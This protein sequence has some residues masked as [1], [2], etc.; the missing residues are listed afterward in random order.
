MVLRSSDAAATAFQP[1]DL[2]QLIVVDVGCRRYF[3]SAPFG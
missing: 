1:D 3:Y 2:P